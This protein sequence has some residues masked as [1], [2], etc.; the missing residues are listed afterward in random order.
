MPDPNYTIRKFAPDASMLYIGTTP[1]GPSIGGYTHD[2]GAQWRVLEADG[3]TT[4]K[5]GTQRITGWETH[6][7]G[8]LK[9]ISN[10][11][12]AHYHP[13]STSDGSTGNNQILLADARSFFAEADFTLQDVRLVYAVVEP[14][15]GTKT[16]NA[17]IY[18]LMRPEN[19]PQSGEDNSEQVREVDWKA[20]LL[21]S[22]ENDEP[23]FFEVA[24][25]DHDNFDIDDYVTFASEE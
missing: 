5:A 20:I 7:R 17:I 1:I 13:G 2:P 24:P 14:S 25:Y 16:F 11:M 10:E 23:P 19:I 22:Q 15:T 21:E 6:L 9:D 18:P 4:E 8:R 12:L 3:L